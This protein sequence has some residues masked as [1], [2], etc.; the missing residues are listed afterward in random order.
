MGIYSDTSIRGLTPD[1]N[2]RRGKVLDRTEVSDIPSVGWT[3]DARG[4]N[5]GKHGVH[6]GSVHYQI[7]KFLETQPQKRATFARILSGVNMPRKYL[8]ECLRELKKQ[9]ICEL[10]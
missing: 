3:R 4:W 5:G 9:G 8:R 6:D 2:M 1:Y 10:F 7:Q